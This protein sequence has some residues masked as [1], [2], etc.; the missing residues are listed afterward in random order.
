MRLAGLTFVMLVALL[1]GSVPAA[2][3]EWPLDFTS[4]VSTSREGDA[5]VMKADT[6]FWRYLPSDLKQA[7]T[8]Y[9]ALEG[10]ES[11]PVTRSSP[12]GADSVVL[13]D[14]SAGSLSGPWEL[15]LRGGAWFPLAWDL[16]QGIRTEDVRV[17]E[18]SFRVRIKPGAHISSI[19][20]EFAGADGKRLGWETLDAHSGPGSTGSEVLDLE[21][22]NGATASQ[23]RR[24]SL[25]LRGSGA[26]EID[27]PQLVA[28]LLDPS[29]LRCGGVPP[30]RL[31]LPAFVALDQALPGNEATRD[32][33]WVE[34]DVLELELGTET[35]WQGLSVPFQAARADAA[36]ITLTSSLRVEVVDSEGLERIAVEEYSDP[37]QRRVAWYE[38]EASSGQVLTIQPQPGTD[39]VGFWA[40]GQRSVT[41]RLRL[42]LQV[43]SDVLVTGVTLQPQVTTCSLSG[44]TPVSEPSRGTFGLLVGAETLASTGVTRF[45][46][47]VASGIVGT[48]VLGVLVGSLFRNRR[49]R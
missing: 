31:Y 27:P 38:A 41:R 33:R 3:A 9:L 30:R 26:V 32:A 4:P 18:A 48:A 29:I 7:G 11:S 34:P 23:T 19:G 17:L 6:P 46:A 42:A 21:V 14:G 45:D 25:W 1:L 35:G 47:F 13:P 12:V 20:I 40:L 43:T 2:R 44:T 16:E 37:D 10:L 28:Q 22:A 24:V 15:T 39:R 8:T 36:G 49:R 5:L